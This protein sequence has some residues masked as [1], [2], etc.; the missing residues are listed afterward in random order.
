M[1]GAIL[2][3]R[4]ALGDVAGR[5]RLSLEYLTS[6]AGMGVAAAGC[7]GACTCDAQVIDAHDSDRAY[8]ATTWK[9]HSF[10]VDQS[11]GS[12]GARGGACHLRVRILNE[13]RSGGTKFKVRSLWATPTGR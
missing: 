8:N 1:P 9:V 10:A 4:V 5:V 2:D 11:K 13:T 12:S 3:A 7:R 6:Y